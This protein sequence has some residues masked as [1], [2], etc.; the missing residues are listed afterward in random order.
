VVEHSPEVGVEEIVMGMAHRGRLN[1]LTSILRKPFEVLF[2]QFSE[3]YIPETVA[4]DGD[5]KYHLGYESLLDTAS[6]RKVEVRLAANPSHLEIVNPVVEGKARAAS[7]S[8][9]TPNGAGS[10]RCWCTGTP[11]SPAR[12]WSPRR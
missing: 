5:V 10:C 1:V 12:V 4:G 9:V 8:G 11:P 7:V 6:G 3:N 2:E